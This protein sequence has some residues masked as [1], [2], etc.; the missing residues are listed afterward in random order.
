M[1]TT[2]RTP[3]RGADRDWP[4]GEEPGEWQST[5]RRRRFTVTAIG[6]A[7]VG[8][9]LALIVG[10]NRSEPPPD[11]SR[12]LPIDG[13]APYWALG[14]S[15]ADL[16]VRAPLLREV[17]PFWYSVTG[18]TTI[19]TDPNVS[20]DQARR[21]IRTARRAGVPVVPSL[22][23]GTDAGVLAAVLA[24]P[25]SRAAH[26]EAVIAFARDGKFDG[27]DLDYE[28]FAFADDRAT[29]A[30][31]RPN[32]IA[33]V[34]ELAE[35]LHAD[36]RTLSVSIPPVYD[37]GQT[38]DSGY[39]VYDYAALARV[40]DRIRVMAYDHSTSSAG[41]IAPL[42]W[43]H[44][45]IDGVTRAAGSPDKL[46]LGVPLYGYTW[47]VG[48][49]GECGGDTLD[50]STVHVRTAAELF[51]R[52]NVVPTFDASAG[53]WTFRYTIPADATTTCTQTR[54]GWYVDAAG[55]QARAEIARQ[56]GWAGV[57]FW[58]LGYDDQSVWNAFA[59]PVTTTTTVG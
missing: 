43:V 8:A 11:R 36:G 13:W 39:W 20:D 32:W 9:T 19:V 56:A 35:R 46:V 40:V 15:L 30:T 58:A 57:S 45:L 28:Q 6:V 59:P 37:D 4:P 47:A 41:P 29:W 14:E 42:D 16:P 51:A 53:E 33:F 25:V 31:T 23:D 24:D 5:Y 44:R 50:R 38:P 26:V 1:L 34:T 49:T 17:S 48:S 52:R 54:E 55:A 10:L 22:F 21:F 3:G 27:I 18:P 2:P 12:V 7:V